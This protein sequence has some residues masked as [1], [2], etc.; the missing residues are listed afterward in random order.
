MIMTT[1][2]ISS[3]NRI[4]KIRESLRK[5]AKRAIRATIRHAKNSAEAKPHSIKRA[6]IDAM[7]ISSSPF[8][9]F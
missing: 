5:T 7:K 8:N 3:K 6:F 1:Q 9:R 4:K 2:N